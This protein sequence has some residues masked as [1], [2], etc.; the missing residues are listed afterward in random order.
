MIYPGD[1]CIFTLPIENSDGTLPIVPTAPTIMVLNLADGSVA[2]PT[3]SMTLVVGT[4][5]TYMAVW[6]TAGQPDGTYLAVVSYSAN[7]KA[8]NGKSLEK[9]R[10]GD[11]RVTGEVAKEATTSKEATAA[12]DATVLHSADYVAPNDSTLLKSVVTKLAGYPTNIPSVADLASLSSLVN[13][14]RDSALGS[15]KIDRPSGT[16]TLYRLDGSL[17]QT[18]N[19]VRTVSLSQRLAV[20]PPR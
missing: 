1:M 19:L 14:V 7:G 5:L 20:G 3:Q 9:V 6:P 18:F 8:F 16:F 10:L 13:D 4:Q 17:L 11:S 12:K 15:W 2:W